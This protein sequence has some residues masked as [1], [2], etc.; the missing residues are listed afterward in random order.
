MLDSFVIT[1][2]QD[3]L[4]DEAKMAAFQDLMDAHADSMVQYIRDVADELDITD[5]CAA[6]VVYLR[7]R[8]RWTQALED[9]LIRLHDVGQAPNMGEFG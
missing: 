5:E 8:S 3:D 4:K 6:D 7:S 1:F 9:E 2:G